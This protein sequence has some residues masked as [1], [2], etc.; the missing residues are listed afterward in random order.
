MGVNIYIVDARTFTDV[1]GWDSD[2]F[3]G[4]RD[5]M[6]V[7]GEVGYTSTPYGHPTDLMTSE[8]PKDVEAF[9][10][11]LLAKFDF[12]QER[13]NRMCDLLAADENRG[14]YFSW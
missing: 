11:A 5:V 3:S 8:R 1:D 6:D 13:W 2:R 4:D 10:A 9:R 7:L 12:N 14:L